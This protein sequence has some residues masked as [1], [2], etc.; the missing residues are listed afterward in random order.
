MTIRFKVVQVGLG[1]M[2]RLIAALLASRDNIH[3]KSIVDIDPELQGKEL[4]ELVPSS[5]STTQ[6]SSDLDFALKNVDVVVV[7]TTSSLIQASPTIKKAVQAGSNVVS[8]CEELSFPYTLHPELSHEL[9]SLAKQYNVTILGTGINPGYLMDLLP[10]VLTAP[11]QEVNKISVTRMM[12]SSKRREPFQRKIGTGLSVPEFREKIDKKEITG[13]VGLIQSIQMIT[14]A[15]GVKYSE[16]K[17]DPPEPVISKESFI[18]SYGVKVEKGQ[19][20]GLRSVAK[21]KNEMNDGNLVTLKFIAYSGD[22]DEYDRVVISGIPSITQEIEGGVHGDLGTAAM[23]ANLI[24][25]AYNARAGLHT[26]K[27]IPIPCNTQYIWKSNN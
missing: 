18:T 25:H 1:P 9:D 17:E 14:A 19:V 8:I 21:A 4:N 13:H 20:C 27:D 22:H 3:L 5:A 11:C 23:V 2:G 7:A 26:M 10:I 24:P 12:N 15:L 16:I 6:V